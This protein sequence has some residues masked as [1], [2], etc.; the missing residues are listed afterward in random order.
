MSKRIENITCPGC[1]SEYKIT[2]NDISVSGLPK[3]CTFC[4]EELYL[5]EPEEP[6]DE[7]YPEG[8]D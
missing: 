3:F 4:S 2:F 6:D 7:Y 5:D 8:D 1:D